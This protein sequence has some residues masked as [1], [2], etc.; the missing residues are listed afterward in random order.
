M[1]KLAVGG[2]SFSD[3]R[4]GIVPYGA[5]VA[6]HYH[7]Q[8]VH[9]AA[10]AGSNYRMWRR[11]TQHIVSGNL[12]A[13]DIIVMQHTLVDRKESWT[14]VEHEN[15]N[16]QEHI[17]ETHSQ[18]S[19]IRL[20]PHSKQFAVGKHERSLADCHNYFTNHEFNLECFWA[21]HHQFAALCAVNN[22]TVRYL[23]TQYDSENRIPD[24]DAQHLL[25]E[26]TWRLDT[27]HLNQVGHDL[28]A[29]LVID[30]LAQAIVSS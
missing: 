21:Q 3:Y 14:P 11:L 28:C 22:I 12:S 20:T 10:C 7:M 5:Q 4:Y 24:I 2:C 23:N 13:G 8:Y 27:S 15:T 16:P 25:L 9:E 17:F 19:I 1:P 30:H 6:D 18:G 26:P 29:R